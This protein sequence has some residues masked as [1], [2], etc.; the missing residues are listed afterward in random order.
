MDD[1]IF[2]LKEGTFLQSK[3][4]ES[5]WFLKKLYVSFAENEYNFSL[6]V[7]KGME[8]EATYWL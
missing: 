4:N 6:G 2:F 7:I 3:C 1:T 8:K 5:V